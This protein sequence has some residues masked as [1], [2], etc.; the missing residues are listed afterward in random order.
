M[1]TRQRIADGTAVFL[2]LMRWVVIALA[3][4]SP[5]LACPT[6]ADLKT[7]ILVTETDGATQ[8]FH[9]V[10]NNTILQS[11]SFGPGEHYQNKLVHGVHPLQIANLENGAIDVGSAILTNYGIPLKDIPKPQPN[12]S[13]TL[14]TTVQTA[15]EP[16]YAD[17][18]VHTLTAPSTFDVGGCRYKSV[19]GRLTYTSDG[20]TLDYA[21]ASIVAQ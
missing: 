2:V 8:V 5:A 1:R 16:T 7:G 19:P 6:T 12:S 9:D 11:G 3:T 21:Y 17:K 18:Q 15:T 20:Y 14:D 13:V 4:A 10:G